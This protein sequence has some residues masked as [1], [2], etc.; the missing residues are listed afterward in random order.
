MSAAVVVAALC[1]GGS[2][3]PFPQPSAPESAASVW[4]ATEHPGAGLP[5]DRA[6]IMAREVYPG[7]T[8]EQL[9]YSAEEIEWATYQNPLAEAAALVTTEFPDDYS[10][11]YFGPNRTFTI[12]FSGDAPAGALATL[13]ATGLPY[14]TLEGLGFTEADYQAASNNVSRQVSQ[15]L[16]A[17]ELSPAASFSV[18]SD[19]TKAPDVI[20]VTITGDDEVARQAALSAVGIPS[21]A[22]PFV[23]TVVE[24]GENEYVIGL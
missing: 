1:L 9:N 24:G 17:E 3:A 19:I 6:S 20:V 5:T 12:A 14:S 2:V 16:D 15:A 13:D 8:L 18:N 23:V 10:L 4:R 11:A 7:V 21:V 22:R